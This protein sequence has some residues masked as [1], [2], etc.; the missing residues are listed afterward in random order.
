MSSVSFRPI[1]LFLVA[2]FLGALGQFFY[3]TGAEAGGDTITAWL[4]N[5]RLILG[6]ICY[7]AIMFI[8]IYAFRLG[9]A[10]T[11]LYPVYATTFIWALLIGIL[12]LNE[13]VS[14]CKVVG[15]GCIILGI[16]LITK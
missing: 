15:V 14:V 7:V 12:L 8:F 16:Y 6:L 13:V 11:V 9:G 10:L 5:Y 2:A 3:K 4:F 1:A